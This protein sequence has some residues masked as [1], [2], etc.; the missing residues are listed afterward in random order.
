MS[1]GQFTVKR[2]EG[3]DTMEGEN[4]VT[5]EAHG[6]HQQTVFHQADLHLALVEFLNACEEE[7]WAELGWSA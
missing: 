3:I 7:E 6:R 5:D 4:A 1:S 2:P